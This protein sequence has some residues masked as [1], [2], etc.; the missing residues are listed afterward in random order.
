M[1]PVIQ[2]E[3]T[4]CGIASA[5]AIAGVSYRGAQSVARSLGV[6]ADNKDLWS[7]TEP[8]RRLL[9]SLGVQVKSGELA[10]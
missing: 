9:E 2:R 7:K 5:A 1:R 8:V 10:R 4:G 3:R 6:V